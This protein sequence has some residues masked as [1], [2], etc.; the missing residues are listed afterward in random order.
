MAKRRGLSG[1]RAEHRAKSEDVYRDAH[2]K[3]QNARSQQSCRDALEGL[4]DAG[5]SAAVAMHEAGW[6]GAGRRG[7]GKNSKGRF[8]SAVS[9]LR[10]NIFK[11]YTG[12]LRRCARTEDEFYKANLSGAR[13][14]RKRK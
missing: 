14:H 11:D 5:M 8:F 9:N 4:F 1:S 7:S 3:W 12:A 13:R 6:S 10:K 2:I